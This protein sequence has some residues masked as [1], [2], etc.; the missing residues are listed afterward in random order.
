MFLSEGLKGRSHPSSSTPQQIRCHQENQG[1][2]QNACRESI[3]QSPHEHP[4]IEPYPI[5]YGENTIWKLLD[6]QKI[7]TTHTFGL[8]K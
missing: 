3:F 4:T 5:P 2:K 1:R 8:G 6:L 7:L